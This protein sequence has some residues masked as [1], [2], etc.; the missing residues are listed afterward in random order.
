MNILG[1]ACFYH[2]ASATLLKDGQLIAAA[3]EERF[4]RKK[5]DSEF[6]LEAI[7]FCLTQGKIKARELDY[8]VF[9]EKPFLKFER[10]FFSSLSN[11]PQSWK[12]FPESMISWLTEKMWIKNVIAEK[13]GVETDKILF[14]PHHLSHA[15]SAFFVSPYKKAAILTLDGVG[16]WTTGT[17][18]VGEGTKIKIL[19][20][21]KFPH[22][23]GLLY[24]VFT[25]FLGFE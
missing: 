4:T 10:L 16:E 25:A 1:I 11:F 23:L 24:S 3:A 9:Y 13:L 17:L 14:V 19:K 20:E 2:E 12:L 18:G 6:P 8:V 15:A 7:K 21:M 5:H 22:S